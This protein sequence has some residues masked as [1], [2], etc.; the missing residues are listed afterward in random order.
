LSGA[1]KK[2]RG[3]PADERLVRSL[4]VGFGPALLLVAAFVWISRRAAAG[5]GLFGLGAA[6]QTLVNSQGRSMTWPGSTGRKR[7]LTRSSTS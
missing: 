5:G 6:A 4:L 1:S 7:R 2:G 3:D